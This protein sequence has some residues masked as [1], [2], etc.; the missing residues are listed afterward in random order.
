MSGYDS[1]RSWG[2]QNRGYIG[3]SYLAVGSSSIRRPLPL[4]DRVLPMGGYCI[5]LPKLVSLAIR[6]WCWFAEGARGWVGDAA[7]VWLRV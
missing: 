7:E 1:S 6:G 2:L 4:P 3:H 5:G